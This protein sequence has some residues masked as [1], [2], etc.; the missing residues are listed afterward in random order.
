MITNRIY[1]W[2]RTQPAKTAI[3]HHERL[4]SYAVFARAIE[5][6]KTFFENRTLPAGR[7]AIVCV[8]NLADAW[9]VVLGLRSLGLNT[10]C[11]NSLT[12]A[13]VLSVRDVA[14]VVLTEAEKA[15]HKLEQS[16]WTGAIIIYFK[17]DRI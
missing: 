9:I 6:T 7:T 17:N 12:V 11:V 1:E 2:A 14:C 5:A 16:I 4:Y 15:A 8:N 3:I 10:I 13:K